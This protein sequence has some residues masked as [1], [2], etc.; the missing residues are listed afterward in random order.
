M[1]ARVR[2]EVRRMSLKFRLILWVAL[3]LLISLTLGAG[4]AWWNATHS[5]ETEMEAALTVGRQTVRA[6]IP[7]VGGDQNA[8][9]ALRQLVGTFD[10]NRHLRASL[11]APDGSAVTRSSL[12]PAAG[13]RYR[14]GSAGPWCRIGCLPPRSHCRFRWAAAPSC[15]KPIRITNS[16]RYGPISATISKSSLC[17]RSSLFRQSIGR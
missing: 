10:G 15:W 13:N 8:A 1:G 5:V 9:D 2:A 14:P 11:L 7:H 3:M 12:L 4:L 6:V 16:P 17:S